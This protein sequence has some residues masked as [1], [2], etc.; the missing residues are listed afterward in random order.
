MIDFVSIGIDGRFADMILANPQFEFN[1]PLNSDTGEL[2]SDKYG[3]FVH[4]SNIGNLNLIVRKYEST[5]KTKVTLTGS[6]HKFYLEDNYQDF[7]FADL[8]DAIYQLTQITEIPAN[9]FIIH[10]LEFGLNIKCEIPSSLILEN[11]ISHIGLEYELKTFNQQG[12]LKR[13]ER[14]H[15]VIKIYD[16]GR[17]CRL[18]QDII[19]FELKAK[20]MQYL[21]KKDIPIQ[22]FA[23]LMNREV[24]TDLGCLLIKAFN[25]LIFTDDRIVSKN[26]ECNVRRSVFSEYS[27]PRSWNSLRRNSYSNKFNRQLKNFREIVQEYSP[28]NIQETMVNLIQ[29]GWNR[30]SKDVLILPVSK[31]QIL[32]HYYID[33]LHKTETS[34]TK[35]CLTCGRDISKQKSTS[36]YCSEKLFGREV[37]RCRNIISNLKRDELNRYPSQTLFD[38]DQFLSDEYR[39]WKGVALKTS[40]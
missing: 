8:V 26:I 12:Y 5:K 2:I 40:I 21:H 15:Y 6:I 39:R 32:S 18:N 19:R 10:Q 35:Q 28:D 30:L 20:K 9:E 37:K 34:T 3:A 31:N 27:N 23:D 22:T 16:K 29:S 38:V 33:V 24:Y 4:S 13:F 1:R 11:I 7:C 25:E 36:K 14:S 17:Q